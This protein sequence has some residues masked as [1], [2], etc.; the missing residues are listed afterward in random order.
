MKVTIDRFEGDYALVELSDR[1]MGRLSKTL[2]PSD[3][4]EGDVV[5]ISVAA[6]ATATEEKKIRKLMGELFE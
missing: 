6:R 4:K 2:L 3:I 5:E 1:K